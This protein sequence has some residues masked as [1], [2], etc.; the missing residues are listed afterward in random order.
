MLIAQQWSPA[1]RLLLTVPLAALTTLSILLFMARLIHSDMPLLPDDPPPQIPPVVR[2]PPPEPVTVRRKPE[3]IE[4]NEPAPPPLLQKW[5]PPSTTG[6]GIPKEFYEPPQM[7]GLTT[8]DSLPFARVMAP[9]TYPHRAA[10]RGIE[11]YVDLRF[12][13][14]ASGTTQNIQVVYAEPEGVFEQSAVAAVARWRFQPQI[15]NGE[16]TPFFGLSKRVRFNM[17]K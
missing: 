9:P 11:G 7:E 1:P 12:D 15:V 4:E 10:Q 13:V 16:P 17:E 2:E 6:G 3:L 5:D 14:S 8:A